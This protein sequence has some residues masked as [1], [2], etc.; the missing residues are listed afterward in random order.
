MVKTKAIGVAV[1]VCV[2]MLFGATAAQAAMRFYVSITGAKQGLFNGEGTYA[3]SM[4]GLTFD[5]ALVSPRDLATGQATGKRT[6]KPIRIRRRG[7][8]RR[9]NSF[10][11]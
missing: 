5:Y 2:L 3:K 4:E 6:H 10:K 1:A 11:R 8:Q 7:V 9:P